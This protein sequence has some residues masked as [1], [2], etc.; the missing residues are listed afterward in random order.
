MSGLV[1][2]ADVFA[3]VRYGWFAEGLATLWFLAMGFMMPM[4]IIADSRG[5]TRIERPFDFG[6]LLYLARPIHLPWYVFR[7]RGAWGGARLAG[8][9]LAVV[10]LVPAERL[11]AWHVG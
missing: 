11:V 4:W 3:F 8:V 9:V 2:V 1:A 7:T 6:F 5:D 10:C